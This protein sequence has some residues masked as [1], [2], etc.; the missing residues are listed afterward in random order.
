M[1]T[2]TLSNDFHRT[3]ATLRPRDGRISRAAW[4]RAMRKLCPSQEC[5][6]GKIR[7]EQDLGNVLEIH[8]QSDGS[9]RVVGLS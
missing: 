2:I 8:E 5:T 3:T 9:Q 7:G 1:Q 4:R 6:C